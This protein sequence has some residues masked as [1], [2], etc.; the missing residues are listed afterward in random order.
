MRD[1]RSTCL[2]YLE[3]EKSLG[4]KLDICL[5]VKGILSS[6]SMAIIYAYILIICLRRDMLAQTIC[7]GCSALEYP[8][9]PPG[10][11][12]NPLVHDVL[13]MHQM[14]II[15]PLTRTKLSDKFGKFA[16]ATAPI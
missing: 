12:P 10:R 16:S 6:L 5:K 15:T 7:S 14:E 13:F 11:T 2:R 1:Y 8:G 9:S 3:T 4:T